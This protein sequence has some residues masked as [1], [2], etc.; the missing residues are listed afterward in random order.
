MVIVAAVAE[1]TA[2]IEL[3]IAKTHA[4]L[5]ADF[6]SVSPLSFLLFLRSHSF[7][8]ISVHASSFIAGSP[9]MAIESKLLRFGASASPSRSDQGAV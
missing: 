2:L 8:S 4:V 1:R 5:K 9:A 6:L 7:S 3:P